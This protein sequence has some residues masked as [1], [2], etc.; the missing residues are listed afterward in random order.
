MCVSESV[1]ACVHVCVCVD[2]AKSFSLLAS[3]FL[4]C[5]LAK[6][7][8]FYFITIFVPHG[9]TSYKVHC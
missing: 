5:T 8:T 1:C 6:A 4:S 3:L 9:E 2:V 7:N